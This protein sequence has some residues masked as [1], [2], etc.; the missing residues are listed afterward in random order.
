[1][2]TSTAPGRSKASSA[3]LGARTLSTTSAP[4]AAAASTISAPAAWYA[5]SGALAARPAP[6]CTL[7]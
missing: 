4:K 2:P 3:T 5:A 1:M 6:A 7:S